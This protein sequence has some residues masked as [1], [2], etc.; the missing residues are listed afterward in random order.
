MTAPTKT[1]SSKGWG[2]EVK[3]VSVVWGH[4]TGLPLNWPADGP[5]PTEEQAP[6]R[7]QLII[8]LADEGTGR[9]LVVVG[10]NPSTA[11][12]KDP[13][14]T[15]TRLVRRATGIFRRIVMLNL[16]PF[17]ATKPPV[18][19]LLH[20]AQPRP[21]HLTTALAQNRVYAL[22]AMRLGDAVL[23]AWGQAA[24]KTGGADLKREM[25]D[26]MTQARAAK[27]GA[28]RLP[29]L[30]LGWTRA[31]GRKAA[32]PRHPLMLAYDVDFEHYDTKLPWESGVKLPPGTPT[33]FERLF[34][35]MPYPKPKRTRR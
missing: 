25:M 3:A 15:L 34:Y 31:E 8:D 5:E 1:P 28:E 6:Y 35:D 2:S 11:N 33:L 21:A 10:A 30:T 16:S 17:R 26:C 32:E 14:P 9:T 23:F 27:G 19:E 7:F 12:A 18:C 29:L 22:E 4:P 24:P 13:D 20:K